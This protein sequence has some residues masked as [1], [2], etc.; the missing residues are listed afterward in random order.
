M[1]WHGAAD[2][3]I[4]HSLA[5]FA[6]HA[7]LHDLCRG[8][9]VDRCSVPGH[10]QVSWTSGGEIVQIACTYAL[11]EIMHHIQASIPSLTTTHTDPQK[12][13][14]CPEA[15]SPSCRRNRFYHAFS[16]CM[17]HTRLRELV[18]CVAISHKLEGKAC[19]TRSPSHKE[20]PVC[21]PSIL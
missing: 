16:T 18:L 2:Y 3:S 15:H 8:A 6:G 12:R 5:S 14:E 13:H 7:K 10:G 17:A 4:S 11:T 20:A 21:P 1:R 19:G 9:A